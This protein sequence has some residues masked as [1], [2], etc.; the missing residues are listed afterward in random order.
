MLILDLDLSQGKHCFTMLS[1]LHEKAD[2][3]FLRELLE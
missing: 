3:C 2:Q 1:V